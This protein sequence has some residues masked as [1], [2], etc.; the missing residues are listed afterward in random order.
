MNGLQLQNHLAAAG[1]GIPIIFVTAYDDNESRRRAMRAGAVAF[2]GKPFNDEQLLE[3][4]RLA[5]RREK[6]S[7]EA[8]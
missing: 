3:T 8:T 4:I 6:L 5:L 2:L 1:C 7:K